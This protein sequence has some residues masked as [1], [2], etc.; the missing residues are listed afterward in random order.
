MSIDIQKIKNKCP[1]TFSK[2]WASIETEMFQ[3]LQKEME[4]AAEKGDMECR[5]DLLK[6]IDKFDDDITETW[7]EYFCNTIE[8]KMKDNGIDAIMDTTW[9][10]LRG[11]MS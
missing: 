10:D 2:R 4:K 8:K 7:F 9:I 3:L 1:T 5:V 6:Y 11:W